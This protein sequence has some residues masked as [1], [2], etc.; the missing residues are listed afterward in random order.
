[1][2]IIYCLPCS[3]DNE[4]EASRWVSLSDSEAASNRMLIR[5]L[6]GRLD[7]WAAHYNSQFSWPLES[8]ANTPAKQCIMMSDKYAND[9]VLS[10]PKIQAAQLLL[11]RLGI[12][13]FRYGIQFAPPWCKVLFQDWYEPVSVMYLGNERPKVTE[14]FVYLGTAFLGMFF[15]LQNGWMRRKYPWLCFKNQNSV[16]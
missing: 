11:N 4:T 12:Q 2:D 7:W 3:G 16:F 15:F 10:A 1:M 6:H 5:S 13:M 14:G 8:V 9:I